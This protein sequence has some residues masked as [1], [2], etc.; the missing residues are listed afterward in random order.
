MTTSDH[1]IITK[2]KEAKTEVMVSE[3]QINGLDN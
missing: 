2:G 1:Q 3:S